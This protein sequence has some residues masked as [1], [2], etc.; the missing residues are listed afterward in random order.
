MVL[1]RVLM[2]G[3]FFRRNRLP[4]GDSCRDSETMCEAG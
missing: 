4:S 2:A 1:I 3:V